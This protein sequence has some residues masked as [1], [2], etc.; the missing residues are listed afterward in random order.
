MGW[1]GLA[2]GSVLRLEVKPGGEKVAHFDAAGSSSSPLL[3]GGGRAGGVSVW[4]PRP[5]QEVA[6]CR[7]LVLVVLTVFIGTLWT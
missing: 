1:A 7:L 3:I 6:V 4:T 2:V 5:H